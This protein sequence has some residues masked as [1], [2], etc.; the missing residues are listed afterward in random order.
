VHSLV[1]TEG[2]VVMH[3]YDAGSK[4]NHADHDYNIM[5]IFRHI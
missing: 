3:M 5:L 4:C 2:Y 1:Y